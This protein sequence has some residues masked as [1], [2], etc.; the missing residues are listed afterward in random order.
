MCK[1]KLQNFSVF[2]KYLAKQMC[3]V[4]FLNIGLLDISQ[5]PCTCTSESGDGKQIYIRKAIMFGTGKGKQEYLHIF[6]ALLPA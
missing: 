5:S 6:L 1:I 4:R 3:Y 2:L